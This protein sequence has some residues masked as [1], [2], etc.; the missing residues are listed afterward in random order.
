MEKLSASGA[1]H[2]LVYGKFVPLL[3]AGL[4]LEKERKPRSR[5]YQRCVFSPPFRPSQEL[6]ASCF[7]QVA[8]HEAS[9][10][11]RDVQRSWGLAT[12]DI[13]SKTPKGTP[14]GNYRPVS[15]WY[16]SNGL[17]GERTKLTRLD[18]SRARWLFCGVEAIE[19]SRGW[20][21]AL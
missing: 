2:P 1:N 12:Y 4:S 8:T 15:S 11:P 20:S 16:V 13:F 5:Q 10:S 9:L 18:V 3:S 19:R 7:L 17:F 14:N 6:R 21:T